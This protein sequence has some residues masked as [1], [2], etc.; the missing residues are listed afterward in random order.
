M[1]PDAVLKRQGLEILSKTIGL[2][3]TERFIA[4]ILRE[5]F[6]YTEWQRCLYKDVPLEKF[7]HDVKEFSEK[8]PEREN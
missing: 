4:L 1:T 8:Q 5:P 7:C 2:V 3:D 6:D